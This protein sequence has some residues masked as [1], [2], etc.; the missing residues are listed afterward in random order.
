MKTT[1]VSTKFFDLIFDLK[2]ETE[3]NMEVL[4]NTDS[5]L[6]VPQKDLKDKTSVRCQ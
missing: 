1:L 2:S 5:M 3:I 6:G 4:V